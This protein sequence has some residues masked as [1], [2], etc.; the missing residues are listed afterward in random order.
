MQ[1]WVYS[2]NPTALQQKRIQLLY[3]SH[4]L[5]RMGFFLCQKLKKQI[6][7]Q[8]I[9]E[10]RKIAKHNKIEMSDYKSDI[11]DSRSTVFPTANILFILF[12]DGMEFVFVHARRSQ[13]RQNKIGLQPVISF[14]GHPFFL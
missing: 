14:T 4:S 5:L 11:A 6:I 9:T 7:Q 12:P 13:Y 10:I 8:L 1:N 2:H 3:V